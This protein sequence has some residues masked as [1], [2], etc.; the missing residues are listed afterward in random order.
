MTPLARVLPLRVAPLEGE[1]IDSWLHALARRNGLAMDRLLTILALPKPANPHALVTWDTA[2]HLRRL[3]ELTGL[4]S[5]RLESTVAPANWFPGAVR[6]RTPR[7]CPPCLAERG[8]RFR[9]TWW[10]PWTF[11]CTKHRV[12]LADHCPT[13]LTRPR[14]HTPLVPARPGLCAARL[15]ERHRC[16]TDLATAPTVALA[17]GSPFVAA[18]SW[19]DALTAVRGALT[20]SVIF[21]DLEHLSNWLLRVLDERDTA[22]LDAA[23]ADGWNNRPT[24]APDATRSAWR[25]ARTAP[26]TAVIVREGRSLLGDDESHAIDRLRTLGRRHDGVVSVC[27]RTMDPRHFAE[28]SPL[29]HN[30]LLRAADP[31]LDPTSRIRFRSCTPGARL[32]KSDEPTARARWV[33]Q[34][35]WPDWTLRMLPETMRADLFRLV[36]S[37]VVL[38][39]GQPDHRIRSTTGHLHSNL[40]GYLLGHTIQGMVRAGNAQLLEVFCRIAD[41]LDAQ[42]SPINYHRRRT[43]ITSDILTEEDWL[44]ICYRTD[45]SPGEHGPKAAAT[46]RFRQAQRYLVQLLTGDDLADP[47][48][49]LTWPNPTHRARYYQ[50]VE[51]FPPAQRKAL[52]EHGAAALL[53][54]G[55]DEPLT[56]SPPERICHDL[57]LPGPRIGDINLRALHRL[58]HREGRSVVQT[59]D[60]LGTNHTH[61][62]FALDLIESRP[63]RERPTTRG[64]T[65]KHRELARTLLTKEFFQ[66]EYVEAGK[67]AGEIAAELDMPRDIVVEFARKAGITLHRAP[68]PRDLD[69]DWLRDQYV[70]HHRSTLSLAQEAGTE[71]MTILRHLR[72]L[73]IPIRPSGV[74]SSQVML[75][76][77]PEDAPEDVRKAVQATR[78]GWL[79]LA[80]FQATMNHPSLKAAGQTLGLAPSALVIQLQ[81]LESDIGAKLFHR[82]DKHAS[83]Q[84]MTPTA[85]GTELLAVLARPEIQDLAP[86]GEF[87]IHRTTL[88]WTKG[89]KAPERAT[90]AQPTPHFNVGM[91][92]ITRRLVAVLHHIHTELDGKEFYGFGVH[93][94]TGT[95]LGTL[96]QMLARLEGMGWLTARPEDETEWLAGA[97]PGCGPGRRRTYYRLTSEGRRAAQHVLTTRKHT[98]PASLS[99]ASESFVPDTPQPRR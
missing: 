87:T 14:L 6:T 71:D 8:G 40:Q 46:P 4:R 56:W 92:R 97:P 36:A 64:S 7:Y 3:E 79:R 81:R 23:V 57:H 83:G 75:A 93:Q 51:T 26:V 44:R 66:R 69:P 2:E 13:C 61:V 67:N 37:A 17:A 28:L 99:Y 41:Y 12:L 30:R 48:H 94:S 18:Q 63:L 98:R 16:I 1:G 54:L 19:V 49:P 95:D 24:A 43:Q 9:L 85:R 82:S 34:M 27:P 77:L 62:R 84:P 31:T 35:L 55:I 20:A 38:H 50:A 52:R 80:R 53:A 33:P 86:P 65:W 70:N 96:Y 74:H 42:G 32:P 15:A 90:G 29:L 73:G 47:N 76:R 22:G 72:Q 60:A 45:T 89:R 21:N 68:R 39:V 10:S 78:Y 11:A 5:G 25:A 88:K 58:V 91:P 59:A